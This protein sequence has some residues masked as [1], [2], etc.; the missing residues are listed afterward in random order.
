VS[1]PGPDLFVVCK[2]CGSEV[3]PYITECPYCGNRLR[4]RAPKLDKE[5]RP[6]EK[7]KRRLAPSLPPLRRGEIPGI[8]VDGRPFATGLLVVSSLV[9]LLLWEAGVVHAVDIGVVG[10]LS[11]EWWRVLSA[12]FVYLNVGYAFVALSAVAVFGWLIERRHG[13]IPVVLIFLAG[14]GLGMLAAASA[15][16]FP[17]AVGGNAGA[18]ALLCAWA[19]APLLE[20]RRGE[21]VEADMLGVL[22]F[23]LALLAL[24]IALPEANPLAAVVGAVV[25]LLAG[26][27]LARLRA[28]N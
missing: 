19:V 13:P 7:P 21:E 16:S 1:S 8:R 15:D 28:T 17:E 18:L 10:P 5:G 26:L 27:P 2:N 24:P 23:A 11:G 4:K 12:N 25:G 22:I 20:M 14:G 9:L 3:S 6:T